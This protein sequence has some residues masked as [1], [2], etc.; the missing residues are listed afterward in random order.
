[1]GF[2]WARG[3]RVRCYRSIKLGQDVVLYK[4][5]CTP[6]AVLVISTILVRLQAM[7]ILAICNTYPTT[8]YLFWYILNSAC[9]RSL[10]QGK[11]DLT[12]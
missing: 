4:W 10:S 3:F 12:Y 6:G 5:R 2:W 9:S 8:C 1:V 7:L 11:K